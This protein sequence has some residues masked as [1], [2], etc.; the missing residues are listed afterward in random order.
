VSPIRIHS[1]AVT[2]GLG[3]LRVEAVRKGDRVQ[4]KF[5]AAIGWRAPSGAVV[6]AYANGDR[7]TRWREAL[8][9]A[10]WH[11]SADKIDAEQIRYSR[12]VE[13]R[14][15]DRVMF[16]TYQPKPEHRP[17]PR[18]IERT[19]AAVAASPAAPLAAYAVPEWQI[20]WENW[21]QGHLAIERT[22][23][24]EE[25]ENI[26]QVITEATAAFADA[27]EKNGPR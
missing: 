13:T 24:R 10:R 11:T 3:P 1:G 8:A 17:R 27:V 4:L 9:E 12:P 22:Q 5:V 25:V 6:I 20:P 26:V 19:P 16:K 7:A 23:S 21:L 14:D 2:S 18:R 15:S